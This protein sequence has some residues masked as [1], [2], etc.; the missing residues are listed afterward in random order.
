MQMKPKITLRW[1]GALASLVVILVSTACRESAAPAPARP[2]QIVQLNQGWSEREARFYNH[3]TEGTNLAPLEFVLNL[4]DARKPGSRFVDTLASEYGF[5]PSGKSPLNPHGLPVGFAIDERPTSFGDRAYVGITCSACHTRQLTYSRVDATGHTATWIMPIHGGPALVDFQRFTR[6][7]YSAF[8]AL[9]DNDKL[10]QEFAQGVLARSPTANDLGALRQEIREFTEPVGAT[11]A[12]LSE[13]KIPAAAFGPGNLNAL[14]Q[15]NYNNLGLIAFLTKKGFVPPTN[16][17]RPTPRLDGGANLPPMWFAH[18]DTWAQWFAEIHHPGP[19]NWVQSVSSSPV[20]PPKMVRALKAGVVLGSIHFDNITQ[21]QRSLEALRTPKW[22]E[23]VLGN[24]NPTRVETGAA[25]YEEH[26]ARCHTRTVLPPN[27]LG[28]AFKNRLAFDVGTDPTAY[29]EFAERAEIRVAG[30]KRLSD[31]ILKL[32]QAQLEG[33]FGR[34]IAMKFM[35]FDSKG[36]PN[37]FALAQDNYREAADANWPRS[38]AAYWAPPLEGI[39]ASSPYFHNGSVRTLSGVLTPPA[40][41][42][43]TFR[44][45]SSDFDPDSVGLRSDGRFLYDT[46]EPGKGNGGHQFG[47]DLPQD[48]KRALIEYLKSL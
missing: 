19:R 23:A 47:T 18:A 43:K 39:F 40:Q 14:S 38:G 16:E 11:R 13:L 9:L 37:E 32:R 44:T 35:K 8:F 34:D 20:R 15:G 2:P 30:L 24:L 21:I 10:A 48:K 41:R 12:I 7:L 1:S 26:C 42:E 22:P 17:P 4:P 29:K 3:A 27:D 28:I 5:I 45:G 31:N 36:R 46:A 6:D 33:K 25:L